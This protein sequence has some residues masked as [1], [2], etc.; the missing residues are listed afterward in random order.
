MLETNKFLIILFSFFFISCQ[1]Q[2]EKDIKEDELIDTVDKIIYHLYNPSSNYV[3]VASHRGNWRNAPENSLPAIESCISLGVDIVEIDVRRTS[4][5][6]LVVIH[7]STLERTTNGSGNINDK[8]LAEIKTFFIKDRFGNLTEYK[9]PTLMEAMQTAKG[10]ILVMIDKANNDFQNVLEV[11]IETETINHAVFIEP[12]QYNEA[13]NILSKKLFEKTHYI[14]RVKENVDHK[15]RYISPFISNKA[16]AAF[17]LRFSSENSHVLDILPTIQAANVS[18]WITTLASDMCANHT[19]YV[20]LTK[21]EDGWGWCI[22]RGAN[23]LLTDYPKL[24]INYLKEEGL[25]TISGYSQT[26]AVIDSNLEKTNFFISPNPI[27][28]VLN[29]TVVEKADFIL[30]NIKGQVLIEVILEKKENKIDISSLFKGIYL[31]NLKTS[32]GSFTRKVVRK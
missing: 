2:D 29:I 15:T 7:D 26:T 10:K 30:L 11:L 23:I 27:G 24:M 5:G 32:K 12:Y 28:G 4:D 9:V 18:I 17:E 6:H 16:A 22:S 20:S 19:D 8:T 21:P 31:L 13:K 1:S 3:M 25:H 14:P